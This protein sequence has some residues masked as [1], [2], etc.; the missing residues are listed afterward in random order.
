MKN[1]ARRRAVIALACGLGAA[2]AACASH[3]EAS[4]RSHAYTESI[5]SVLL[6]EDGKHLAAIGANHHYLFDAPELLVRALHSPAHPQL[7]ATFSGFHVD[8][9]GVVRGDWSLAMEADTPPAQRDAAAAI[10]LVPG[11]DGRLQARGSL[12][13]QRYTGWTYKMGREQDRLNK[14]YVIELTVD[15]NRGEVAADDAATPIRMTADGVQMLYYAPLAPLIV[16][17]LFLTRARDH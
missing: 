2:L 5:S 17:F 9:R 4:T 16:P 11:P 3:D 15:A 14:P 1:E 7:Q 8:P 10:G 13:G 6:S 12:V